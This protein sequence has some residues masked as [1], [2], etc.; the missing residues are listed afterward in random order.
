MR[1]NDCVSS[2]RVRVKT[3]W[4][5][6]D[7]P[8]SVKVIFYFAYIELPHTTMTSYRH[9][10]HRLLKRFS[11]LSLH[12]SG[13]I[14]KTQFF[15]STTHTEKREK[16]SKSLH[17]LILSP[18]C[19]ICN[20]SLSD[21]SLL[22]LNVLCVKHSSLGEFKINIRKYFAGGFFVEV[23]QKKLTDFHLCA[24]RKL[25]TKLF[26]HEK[27]TEINDNACSS[28]RKISTQ[29]RVSSSNWFQLNV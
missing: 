14:S 15:F 28:S 10:S 13:G 12:S 2:L 7:W 19:G 24:L 21:F 8:H 5:G 11:D 17:L 20:N 22:L 16:Y 26:S 3:D 1:L 25:S 27:N 18:T 4:F 6:A 29:T 23:F 9:F